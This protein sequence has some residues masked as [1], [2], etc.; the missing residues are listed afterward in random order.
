MGFYG[1]ITN[2]S[3]TQFSFDRIY[4][5]RKAMDAAAASD[6]V[7]I[8]RYVLV[9]YE[10]NSN[11]IIF[12]DAYKGIENG[13]PVFGTGWDAN[14][15]KI[16][17]RF[18]V[19]SM[20]DFDPDNLTYIKVIVSNNHYEDASAVEYYK[21]N[22]VEEV[23][24]YIDEE[25]TESHYYMTFDQIIDPSQAYNINYNEDVSTYGNG[26]G[27]D[28]TA[29]QKI[30]TAN[31]EVKYVMIAELNS[32]VPSFGITADAPTMM[33]I[34]PH[35]DADSTNIYYNLH[36]PAAWGIRVKASDDFSIPL[37]NEK[38][39]TIGVGVQG[40]RNSN[41]NKVYPSDEKVIW[42][43]H[44]YNP[45]QETD[46]IT[47]LTKDGNSSFWRT[48]QPNDEQKVPAAIYYNKDGFNKDTISYSADEQYSGWGDP[49]AQGN[50][51]NGR[52]TDQIIF[53]NSGYSGHQYN[54]HN[55]ESAPSP[56]V[57]TLELSIMLP[58]LGDTVAKM[59]DL[60]YGGRDT[61][62][63]IADSGKR[64]SDIEWENASGL[65]ARKGLR[66]VSGGMGTY[67]GYSPKESETVAGVINSIHDLMGMII[68]PD[69][70]AHLQDQ[71]RYLSTN[72]I[73]YNSDNNK[74]YRKKKNYSYNSDNIE[75]N[76]VEV[77]GVTQDN[78]NPFLYYQY[79]NDEYVP[80]TEFDEHIS[81]YYVKQL[82]GGP[83][84]QQVQLSKFEPY[85]YWYKD[86]TGPNDIITDHPSYLQ[87]EAYVSDREYYHDFSVAVQDENLASYER[88]KFYFS[89]Q[90]SKHPNLFTFVKDYND[91]AN[92]ERNYFNLDLTKVKTV[93]AALAQIRPDADLSRYRFYLPGVYYIK[94]SPE[95]AE[96]ASYSIFNG[97]PDFNTMYYEA[98]PDPSGEEITYY[99]ITK[100]FTTEQ[101]TAQNYLSNY[102]WVEILD[103]DDDFIAADYVV[104][105]QGY[106]KSKVYKQYRYIRA[107]GVDET[108]FNPAAHYIKTE[109]GYELAIDFDEEAQYYTQ[110]P[111]VYK[112]KTETIEEKTSKKYIIDGDNPIQGSR[113]IC[114]RENTF[115]RKI[116]G[117]NQDVMDNEGKYPEGYQAL[118]YSDTGIEDIV[119]LDRIYVFYINSTLQETEE[120]SLWLSGLKKSVED[121]HGNTINPV[122]STDPLLSDIFNKTDIINPTEWERYALTKQA[123]FYVPNYY[124]LRIPNNNSFTYMDEND[125]EKT[126]YGYNFIYDSTG[127]GLIDSAKMDLS[128]DQ[129]YAKMPDSA[130]ENI[131][132]YV[133]FG[134]NT[135][136]LI[137][138]SL[139]FYEPNKY[140][141]KID[142]EYILDEDEWDDDVQYWEKTSGKYYV[143]SDDAN[144]YQQGAEWN[145][146]I[147][148]IP[149]TITLGERADSWEL[150]EMPEFARGLTTIH[151]LLL[152][153]HQ[154]LEFGDK[155][156]RDLNTAQGVLNNLNDI[157]KKINSLT[158]GQTVLVNDYGQI[159]SG[160]ITKDAWI[161]IKLDPTK[162]HVGL[163]IG[164]HDAYTVQDT[165]SSS[166]VNGN[167]D[168]INLD[169][170]LVDRKG[171]VI[172]KNTETV[173]LPYGYKTITVSANSNAVIDALG[174]AGSST[175][176]STQDTL[177]LASSNKWIKLDNATS[178]TVKIGHTVDS[179]TDSTPTGTINLFRSVDATFSAAT[180]THDEAGHVTGMATTTY[181]LPANTVTGDTWITPTVSDNGLALAH[182][183]AATVS[184]TIGESQNR[185]PNFGDTFNSLSI[186]FDANGH[187]KEYSNYTITIPEPSLSTTGNG[188]VV[189][190]LSLVSSTGALTQT[191]ENLG[192]IELGTYTS[193]LPAPEGNDP[194]NRFTTITTLGSAIASLEKGLA[195]EI[196]NRVNAI[197]TEVSNR[198][199][200]ITNALAGLDL[201][202]TTTLGN[203]ALV[204]G[205][206]EVIGS[207]D[208]IDGV[209]YAQTKTLIESDIPALSISKITNLQT[210]LD[211][212]LSS[213]DAFT[214]SDADALY[215]PIGALTSTS[216]AGSYETT[217]EPDPIT[218][219]TSIITVSV[220]Y[221][222][223]YDLITTLNN[224]ISV[225]TSRVE[226][227]EA[228]HTTPAEP[229]PEPEP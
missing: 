119:D 103:G 153:L 86:Y 133:L 118:S 143:I 12:V 79:T 105:E 55:N 76:Y 40:V 152:K 226:A 214:Q 184:S 30:I 172:G 73:Y 173:T 196:A 95:G 17:G 102:Y 202:T 5:S 9:E 110:I 131:L 193:L 6:G 163:D 84:Y 34:P 126:S 192:A 210:E 80:I 65:I 43:K 189:T 217:S 127:E 24:F 106:Y 180:F 57:D 23:V 215:S 90:D 138:S 128:E 147:T 29:W 19:S 164:H 74:Y 167:G 51:T 10:I 159:E 221:G 175:A 142:E 183:G 113:F 108:N 116:N 224:K 47:Y 165:T 16:T 169:T 195:D 59:W 101:V 166:N 58:S 176:T 179:I 141:K 185:T 190:G 25:T 112:V 162:N 99:I 28:S 49:D 81:N 3:R 198:N 8:G 32:I 111:V 203:T 150:V 124:Y 35:F 26:R 97:T 60:L 219:E 82:I 1:N 91:T 220:T 70:N 209:V 93:K 137:D 22:G 187:Y 94:T 130:N 41:N 13:L 52:V 229:E 191:T 21:E 88:G 182:N 139:R 201:D 104:D 115:W 211:N 161:D 14:E 120:Q 136:T 223:L 205:T 197:S 37:L 178:K 170:P 39:E 107:N 168:T 151:G 181:T 53:E 228:Y 225:L 140:Y 89:I 92:P 208:Q 160:P 67:L 48:Q 50:A 156:T 207:I 75:Y 15:E 11:D 132:N 145:D 36:M 227:L 63:T 194:D 46:E 125:V 212:K 42:V 66:L 135:P 121:E 85:K 31:G 27:Y 45:T 83:E 96:N 72:R 87:D 64:N 100:N 7:F 61:N 146:S 213:A 216:E 148:N 218:G 129:Q 109:E 206:G 174:A 123:T 134:S 20:D 200:A 62:L 149:N 78:F 98:K 222:Q 71:I 117:A 114:W 186:G 204:A 171:H 77:L 54:S 157:L 177:T 4:S 199:T 68:T 154:I 158:P 188:N 122:Y 44:N 2:T 38:G 144:V 69:T 56:K 18:E 155:D 33:P